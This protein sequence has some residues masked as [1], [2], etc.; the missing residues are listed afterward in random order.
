MASVALIEHGQVLRSGSKLAPR[1]AGGALLEL[2]DELHVELGGVH[3]VLA[4][5]GPGSFTGTRVA[6]I[7]AKVLAWERGV[8]VSGASAFD[9]IGP[10]EVAVPHRK[11]EWMLR[12]GQVVRELP[13][14]AVGYGAGFASPTYPLAER[15]AQ[16]EFAPVEP[17]NFVP[18]YLSEPSIS[19]PKRPYG[20]PA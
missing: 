13:P 10:G 18:E 17:L 2:L 16:L 11:G 8:P 6:V 15:A 3:G 12:G 5:V 1:S 4:D 20:A 14:G 9:L 19:Q 7:L